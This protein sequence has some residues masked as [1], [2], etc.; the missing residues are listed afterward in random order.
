MLVDTPGCRW[1]WQYYVGE[2]HERIAL[3][4]GE[5]EGDVDAQ[6]ILDAMDEWGEGVL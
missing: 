4:R 5:R 3:L 2:Y 6:R 1:R